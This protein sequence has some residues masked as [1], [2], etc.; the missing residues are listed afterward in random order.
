MQP[1]AI[2]IEIAIVAALSLGASAIYSLVSLIAK[3]TTTGISKST[4]SINPSLSEQEWL[5]A[6]YN[7]LGIA[8]GLAPVALALYLLSQTEANPFKK[9]GLAP[10]VL[11]DASRGVALAAAIGIPGIALYLTARTLGLSAKVIPAELNGY[12]WLPVMLLLAAVRAALLEEVL[13]IA[14]LYNRLDKLNVR[15]GWQLAASALLRGCYHLYQG[16]GG[17]IGNLIMGLVFGLAYRRWGRVAPLVFA[18]F[19]LDAVSFVGY[20]LLAKQLATWSSL[21]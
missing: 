6:T 15:F 7:F 10:L 13:M 3:I 12:W 19:I 21:F 9:I 4:A 11:R 20:A 8:F 16:I 2:K 1:R 17:F 14:Y 18:H 5:D